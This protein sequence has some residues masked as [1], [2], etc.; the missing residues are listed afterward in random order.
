MVDKTTIKSLIDRYETQDPEQ[1][2]FKNRFLEFLDSSDECFKRSHLV[3]HIT[4]STLVVNP[5]KT[6]VILTLHKKLNCWLQPGGH[7][8]GDSDPMRVA[9]K[10]AWEETGI[11]GIQFLSDQIFDLDIHTI[12]VFGDVPEHLHFDVRFLMQAPHE[13]FAISEE[14]HDLKWFTF[15]ESL[16][17]DLDSS[18]VR[19]IKRVQTL[20]KAH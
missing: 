20:F 8:D 9:A 7:A 2:D 6:K 13:N 10:E 4:G 14:S 18:L 16:K 1:I 3:G 11:D 17:E 19:M 15:E 5:D 12:P